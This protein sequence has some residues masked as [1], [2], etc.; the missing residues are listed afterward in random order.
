MVAGASVTVAL[1]AESGETE[2]D[3]GPKS[4]HS[5]GTRTRIPPRRKLGH[6]RMKWPAAND[7]DWLKLDEDV[8]KCLESISKG[9]V[10]QKLQTMCTIIINMGAQW[11]GVEERGDSKPEKL[12]RR[13]SK[14]SQLRQELN[15]L[16]CQLKM[17]KKE[18]RTALSDLTNILRKRLISLKEG[19]TVPKEGKERAM[20]SLAIPLTLQRTYRP[21]REATTS[22]A[23]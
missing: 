22:L 15:F 12:N 9:S 2:E 5:T 18:E 21:R 20:L 16:R 23:R 7:K 6:H 3:P 19:G 10:D 11:F 14:I 13:E 4:P 1:T 8:D 17:T